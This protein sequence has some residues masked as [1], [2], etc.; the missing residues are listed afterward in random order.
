MRESRSSGSVRGAVSNGC[1]YREKL[2]RVG[3]PDSG[4]SGSQQRRDHSNERKSHHEDSGVLT[5]H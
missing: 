3:G 5:P 2:D 4:L 1:P